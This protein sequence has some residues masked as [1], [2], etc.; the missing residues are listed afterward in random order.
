[1]DDIG[2]LRFISLINI[3]INCIERMKIGFMKLDNN[4]KDKNLINI[5]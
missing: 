5:N 1:M 4:L 3:W 2:T